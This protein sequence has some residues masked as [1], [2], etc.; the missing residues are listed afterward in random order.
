M[1]KYKNGMYGGKFLPFH[2]GHLRCMQE[3]AKV[4]E[5]LWLIMFIGGELENKAMAKFSPDDDV[6]YLS[7]EARQK[8]IEEI[9]KDY[10]NVKFVV[11]DVSS[12]FHDGFED[13]DMQ[14]P[15]VLDACGELDAVFGSE[16]SYAEYF[17][18]AYPEADYVVI[19]VDR[20]ACPISGTAVR[21]MSAEER[22]KWI[23]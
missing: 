5:T 19:D 12:T 1:K 2:K 22:E 18:R 14:T 8:R 7:P 4:C 9:V 15:M 23:A 21:E 6:S 3:A 16:P 20:K 10:P 11:L 17:S 13:W